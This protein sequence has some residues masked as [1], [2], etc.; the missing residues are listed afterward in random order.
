MTSER[1]AWL[2]ADDGS[3][4]LLGK[5][6]E[7]MFSPHGLY[8]AATR[9]RSL[10]AVD[11]AGEVRWT[12]SRPGE[13][14]APR[15]A[16]SGYRIAFLEGGSVWV[17]PGDAS[18]EPVPLDAATATAP[19]WRPPGAGSDAETEPNVL[20]YAQR[21]SVTTRDA[22]TGRVLFRARTARPARWIDW[23]GPDRLAVAN[24]NGIRIYDRKGRFLGSPNL[25]AA[26]HVESLAA[27]PD[28]ERLAVVVR[29]NANPLESP[30]RLLLIRI[31]DGKRVQR[32][33][34]S[35]IGRFGEP[36]FSPGGEWILLP[37]GDTDQWLFI[38]P[39][40]DRKLLRRVIAVGNVARQ[41]DPGGRGAGAMPAVEDWCCP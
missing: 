25:P 9:G 10:T 3:R 18:T 29:E 4:R 16:P 17:V 13:V 33:V 12:I 11:P 28:G 30:A 19:A 34:F 5:Y 15:W 22:D 39:D 36:V 23:A 14:T 2:V 32:T 26:T 38:N 35:G 8:V 21:F 40:S 7:A 37:W 1:G 31:A 27:S 24:P 41:F 20:T 6:R